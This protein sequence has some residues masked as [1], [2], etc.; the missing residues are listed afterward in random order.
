MDFGAFPPERLNQRISRMIL[1]VHKKTSTLAVLGE[2]GRFP[3]V[4]NSLVHTIKYDWHLRQKSHE[5]YIGLAYAEMSQFASLGKY[6]WLTRV[7]SIK[8]GLDIKVSPYCK[9]SSAG[10]QI[11]KQIHSKYSSCTG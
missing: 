4:V 2:L 8:S 5:S 11:K 1:S 3:L 9:P 10:K 7:N 6:C